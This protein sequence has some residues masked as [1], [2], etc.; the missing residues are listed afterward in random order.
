MPAWMGVPRLGGGGRRWLRFYT[1]A[2]TMLGPSKPSSD[3][4]NTNT[5]METS[6]ELA[7]EYHCLVVA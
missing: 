3:I 4:A 1:V 5:I 7:E 6:H 2:R